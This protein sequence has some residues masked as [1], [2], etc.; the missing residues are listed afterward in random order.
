M[1]YQC[2]VTISI[3]TALSTEQIRSKQKLVDPLAFKDSIIFI[4]EIPECSLL[5]I[6]YLSPC[7][8]WHSLIL[9]RSESTLSL[10]LLILHG[11]LRQDN[12][13]IQSIHCPAV[14]EPKC[15]DEKPSA[16]SNGIQI[17]LFLSSCVR[18]L[19]SLLLLIPPILFCSM[20]DGKQSH[21]YYQ[22]I[23]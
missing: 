20:E 7:C 22:L 23:T 14:G 6:T 2:F 3:I 9:S 10:C 12:N 11:T 15:T 17:K 4:I 21:K 19:N 5:P 1:G 8:L 16:N 13:R 18:K